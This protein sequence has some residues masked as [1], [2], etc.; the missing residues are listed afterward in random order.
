MIL[1]EVFL[2]GSAGQER[3]RQAL[4][5]SEPFWVG[6]R[7]DS[8]LAQRRESSR[9]D[10]Q[11]GMAGDKRWASTPA[12]PTTWKSIPLTGSRS[13]AHRT[14]QYDSIRRGVRSACACPRCPLTVHGLASDSAAGRIHPSSR[15]LVLTSSS[16]TRLSRSS[17]AS[18]SGASCATESIFRWWL[19]PS[20]TPAAPLPAPVRSPRDRRRRKRRDGRRPAPGGGPGRCRPAAPAGRWS[21][22]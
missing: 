19:L 4:S 3:L 7:C 12:S 1:D 17:R 18:E 2:A 8:D 21:A 20:R 5:G 10:R 22:D 11:P 6:V 13:S 9:P 16:A 14:S 15:S